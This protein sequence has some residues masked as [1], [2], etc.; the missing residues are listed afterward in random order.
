MK[1][2]KLAVTII[3]FLSPCLSIAQ[4]QIQKID[5]KA[6]VSRHNVINT[7]M[8]TLSSL[9]VGNGNFAF[10]VDATGMQT[11]PEYY[12]KEVPLGTQS[13]WGWGNLKLS[14]E[15]KFSET[16]KTYHFN[17]RDVTYSVQQNN[18]PQHV[19]DAV[20]YF[21]ENPHR[22]QLGNLGLLIL[23][24][25]GREINVNDIKNIHQEL[26]LWTGTI[27][28]HFTVEG[29]TVDVVTYAHGTASAIDVDVTSALVKQGRLKIR[30]RFPYPTNQFSDMGTNY[31][32]D[33]KH[34][35]E[36]GFTDALG[37]NIHHQVDGK[38]YVVNLSWNGT[39]KVKQGRAHEYIISPGNTTNK[40]VLSC[41]FRDDLKPFNK[42][43]IP[44][45]GSDVIKSSGITAWKNY[46][47]TGG[48]VDLAGSTDPRA[49][50]LE[51][52]IVL[53]QYLMRVNCS[54]YEPPQETGLTY[55]SWYGR[56]HLEMVWWHKIHFA[57]W[58]H[59]EL[60]ENS[61]DWFKKIENQGRAI[62]ERQGYKGVRWPKMT[63]P[64][65]NESPSSVG[66][67]LIWQQPHP[68]Y[69]A[70]LAYRA[71]PDQ[72]TLERYKDIVFSTAEFMA[73]YAYFDKDKGTYRL[74]KGLIPSQEVHKAENT[75]NPPYEL[76]YWNWALGIAQQWRER[77]KLPRDKQW[78]EVI[79]KLSPLPKKDGV[80][81]EAESAPDSYT[82]PKNIT[83][84]P[85]TLAAYGMMPMSRMMDT[86]VMHR[87]F[88]VI[89]KG[90]NWPKTWGWDFPMTAMTAARLNM[91]EKAIDALFMDV[92]TNTY[93]PD[94]H[95][96]QDG[97]LT[98][99]L[100]GNGGLLT[101]IAMMCAGWD[102]SKGDAPGFPKNGKWKVKWEGLKRM[103]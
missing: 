8:D 49:N 73:S 66:A 86:A 23:K 69:M 91:P 11:F 88:D 13:V 27:K 30:V 41:N 25:D 37:T 58:G 43:N 81:L 102:G 82:N 39:A 80:Y 100:P 97:R 5:R 92:K 52:R 90:W 62:A 17:G 83:D 51:R 85:S 57:L 47:S 29:E 1:K 46:W 9:S 98:I 94:G 48:A 22:L 75:F 96:Y 32:N 77:L 70:E 59:P 38:G 7:A 67:F 76:T 87:T 64:D 36:I 42:K 53:S 18:A 16:L 93:L 19:K 74:G 103:P 65:G 50:E 61:L 95:N 24:K 14:S 10:T 99:Y 84:H 56:P 71:H 34:T 31:N 20:N 54:G 33:D 72:K 6:L 40:L 89:W 68:I 4:K 35:S 21:R 15:Y 3:F 101:T 55:N 12:K 26:D 45:Y 44:Y 79:N 78:D 28:S 63:D 60:M 2:F